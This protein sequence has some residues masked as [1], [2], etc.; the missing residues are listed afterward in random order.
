MLE[1]IKE[2]RPFSY[3]VLTYSVSD[4]NFIEE[5]KCLCVHKDGLSG[6]LTDEDWGKYNIFDWDHEYIHELELMFLEASK[7]YFRDNIRSVDLI[8]WANLR[9][10]A[11]THLAH[12]HGNASLIGNFYLSTPPN[13]SITLYNPQHINRYVP[14]AS[15]SEAFTI[16]VKAGDLII[17]P[18]WYLHEVPPTGEKE[19]RIS[20]S[21]NILE[22]PIDKWI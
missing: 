2:E 9:K 1:L 22:T 6:N 3:P 14:W 13:S 8:G 20:I 19:A 12:T 17:F 10:G 5:L 11:S 7:P 16:N 4:S 18:G 21:C 15:V